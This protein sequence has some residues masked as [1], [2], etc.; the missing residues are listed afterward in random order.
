MGA[1]ACADNEREGID[2]VK[3]VVITG[4]AGLLGSHFSR[5][6]I[7]KGYKVVGIDNLS[8]GYADYLPKAEM[9]KFEFWPID[10]SDTCTSKSLDHIFSNNDV[11]AC[12]HF[13]AYAAEG[14]SPFI[15][16]FNY[17]NNILASVNIIN[18]CIKHDV[19]MVF[20]SSMAVYG[21]QTPPFKESMR[22]APMDP[23]GIAKY[24]IEMDL[25]VAKEQHELR[26]SIVRPHNIIGIYQ[27]IWDRYRNVA[28][29]F[30]RKVLDGEPMLI[31]GDG[32]QTRAFSDVKYYMEPFEQLIN[33]HD[34]ELFNLGADKAYSINDLAD[35][36][37]A[38]ALKNGYEAVKK[39]VE[40]RHEVKY[41]HC[42]HAKAKSLLGFSDNTNLEGLIDEMFNWALTQPKREQKIMDYEVTKGI[43]EYWK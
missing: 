36:V 10:L 12:Y 15:R 4:C 35:T 42:D 2:A 33:D 8:G 24:A 39:H 17:E 43:Y 32:E 21:N 11:V 1:E 6:L 14:L 19:K 9:E 26:Y 41:A 30:I 18:A 27:N 40:P 16:M 5:H 31:Y 37:K 23:Y 3:T 34:G 25:E 28:G 22:Q 38:I 20:T 7:N 13:A 29:I